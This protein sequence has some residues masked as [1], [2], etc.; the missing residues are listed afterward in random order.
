MKTLEV[1]APGREANEGRP[2]S[3]VGRKCVRP[4]LCCSAAQLQCQGYVSNQWIYRVLSI[5][6]LPGNV[7]GR[8]VCRINAAPVSVLGT[9]DVI[10]GGIGAAMHAERPFG[11]NT[12]AC[13]PGDSSCGG[14]NLGI[15]RRPGSSALLAFLRASTR[16]ATTHRILLKRSLAM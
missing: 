7:S 12:P 10:G 9:T 11:F 4:H 5:E 14:C 15:R 1:H 2:F 6:F 3:A 13:Q 16:V 8:A